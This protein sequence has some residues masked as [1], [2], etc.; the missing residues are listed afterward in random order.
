MNFWVPSLDHCLEVAWHVHHVHMYIYCI[1]KYP[2]SCTCHVRYSRGNLVIERQHFNNFFD[3]HTVLLITAINFW[4]SRLDDWVEVVLLYMHF[5]CYPTL[6][7]VSCQTAPST[8]SGLTFLIYW[9]WTLTGTSISYINRAKWW[10]SHK[11]GVAFFV[12]WKKSLNCMFFTYFTSQIYVPYLTLF[13]LI[14]Q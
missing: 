12:K 4:L 6:L 9:C 5:K 10:R 1:S 13:L 8:N 7:H 3:A 11:N 2:P 14:M